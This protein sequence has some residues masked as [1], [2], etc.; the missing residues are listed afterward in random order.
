MNGV[1]F[2]IEEWDDSQREWIP[3]ADP[4]VFDEEEPA[5]TEARNW[6]TY[7]TRVAKYVRQ[8]PAGVDSQRPQHPREWVTFYTGGLTKPPPWNPPLPKG[9]R[10]MHQSEV[11]PEIGTW[12]SRVL[13]TANTYPMH[14]MARSGALACLVQWHTFQGAT[15]K[16]GLFRG[17]SLIVF[18]NGEEPR[19]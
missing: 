14:C 13:R 12:A 15:G 16:H 18:E 9:A 5:V 19:E 8:A 1:L 7:R 6:Q 10:Y 4:G 11:T 2:I 3:M 17:V